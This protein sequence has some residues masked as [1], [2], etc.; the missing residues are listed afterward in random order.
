MSAGAGRSDR[1]AQTAASG[2]PSP[3][4]TA[5]GASTRLTAVSEYPPTAV[6]LSA[7]P[8][9]RGGRRASA[10]PVGRVLAAGAL[11]ALRGLPIPLERRAS[12]RCQRPLSERAADAAGTASA[13]PPNRGPRWA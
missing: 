10:L 5:S 9:G 4:A 12:W 2:S 6:I 1:T 8:P 3:L 7:C 11:G 13:R